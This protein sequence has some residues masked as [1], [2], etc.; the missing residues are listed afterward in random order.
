M[1]HNKK[2]VLG[3]E[4]LIWFYRF[5]LITLIVVAYVMIVLHYYTQQYD[6]R[7]AEAVLLAGRVIDCA[8]DDGIVDLEN[9]SDENIMK[10]TNVTGTEEYIF[11]NLSYFNGTMIRKISVGDPDIKPI[12]DLKGKAPFCLE[13]NY[14]LLFGKEKAKLE[15]LVGMLK[16]KESL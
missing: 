5:F 7:P 6:T 15:L 11:G 9:F 3:G 8:T 1:M 4:T 12:C 14:Y 16:I 2:A 13:Q 10:C